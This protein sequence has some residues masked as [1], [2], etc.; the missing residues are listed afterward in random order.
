MALFYQ[1]HDNGQLYLPKH[2][3]KDEDGNADGYSKFETV[4]DPVVFSPEDLTVTDGSIVEAL[5]RTGQ[6]RYLP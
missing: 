1:S 4:V 6:G 2:V 5:M 3:D